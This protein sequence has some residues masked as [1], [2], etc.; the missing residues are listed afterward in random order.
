MKLWTAFGKVK[1]V[2][3]QMT[4]YFSVVSMTAILVTAWHTTVSP[5]LES[6]NITPSIWWLVFGLGIPFLT[7][8]A[9]EW[10]KGTPGYYS[11]FMRL[12]Y[13]EDSKL[14]R[15]IDELKKDVTEIKSLIKKE[16]E[17]D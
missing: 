7:L 9:I 17:N 12:F 8:G 6:R 16:D 1:Q 4:L 11:S 3:A 10:L 14:R 15:D 2:L 13:T 5:I